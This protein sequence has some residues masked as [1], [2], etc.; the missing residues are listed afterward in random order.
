MR[1]LL[2]INIIFFTIISNWPLALFAQNTSPAD[3]FPVPPENPN[4]LFYLQRQPN[5]N[6]IIYALNIKNNKIDE[7]DPVRVYWIRYPEKGQ[8]EELSWIQRTFAYGVHSKRI[9]GSEYEL[10]IVSYKKQKI[11]LE[12]DPQ[13]LWRVSTI[14]S[15]GKKIV[16]KRIYV[17]INGGS[18][19]HPN[20]EYAELKGLEPGSNRE[21]RERIKIK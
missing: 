19:W 13:G 4:L 14:L 3:T 15:N 9:S 20:I 8:R 11:W 17:H 2:L 18:F 5:T 16:L 12:K 10:N 7:D 6:T 1:A 21:V